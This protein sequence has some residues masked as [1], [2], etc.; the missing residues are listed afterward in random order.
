MSKIAI[1][2]WFGDARRKQELT[3]FVVLAFLLAP[4]LAIGSVGAYGLGVWIYQMMAG[5]PS[6]LAKTLRSPGIVPR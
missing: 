3:V 6:S 2:A 5:P 4:V 1:R